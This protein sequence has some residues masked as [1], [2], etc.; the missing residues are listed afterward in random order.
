MTDEEA[1][2]ARLEEQCFPNAEEFVGQL[3]SLPEERQIVFYL[4]MS[5]VLEHLRQ[6]PEWHDQ[7]LCP[8]CQG[9][10]R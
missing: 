7:L 1:L 6:A 10:L 5:E 3:L 9:M 2:I 4:E 8:Y